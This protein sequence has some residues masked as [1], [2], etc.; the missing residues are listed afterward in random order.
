MTLRVGKRVFVVA[1]TVDP[2]VQGA[3]GEIVERTDFSDGK[4][5]F[6]VRLNERLYPFEAFELCASSF[7]HIGNQCVFC[8]QKLP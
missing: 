5:V 6:E 2:T 1:G 8:D 3:R 4:V 7:G